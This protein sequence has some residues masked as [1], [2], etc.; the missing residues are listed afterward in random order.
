MNT[1]PL[2]FA[3]MMQFKHNDIIK[4][5]YSDYYRQEPDG[6]FTPISRKVCFDFSDK[7][8]RVR[9]FADPESGLCVRLADNASGR[10]L[11]Q[12]CFCQGWNYA[13]RL[14]RGLEPE[15]VSVEDCRSDDGEVFAYD[16]PDTETDIEEEYEITAFENWL[17]SQLTAEERGLYRA[18]KNG[19]TVNQY[20]KI[21]AAKNS[22]LKPNS[23]WRKYDRLMSKLIAKVEKLRLEWDRL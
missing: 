10:Q 19:Y 14:E 21:V 6:S 22:D 1:K 8:K 16:L 12:A 4:Y 2:T 5:R 17:E 18:V 3:E 11:E 13:K 20:S 15:I 23:V 7:T 9:F